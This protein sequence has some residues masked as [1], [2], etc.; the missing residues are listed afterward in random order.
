MIEFE[1]INLSKI[2]LLI[3]IPLEFSGPSSQKLV[4]LWGKRSLRTCFPL[5]LERYFWNIDLDGLF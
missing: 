2:I 5:I 4:L 3:F 1:I